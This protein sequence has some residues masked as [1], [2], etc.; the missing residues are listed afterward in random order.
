[1][2][3]ITNSYRYTG[4]YLDCGIS[5]VTADSAGDFVITIRQPAAEDEEYGQNAKVGISTLEARRL[6]S[7]LR[8]KGG[9]RFD[10]QVTPFAVKLKVPS[11]GW[12]SVKTKPNGD[13]EFAGQESL[14]GVFDVS[15]GKTEFVPTDAM[16]G[17][18]RITVP[19]DLLPDF[20]D[21]VVRLLDTKPHSSKNITDNLMPDMDFGDEVLGLLEKGRY[22]DAHEVFY[23]KSTAHHKAKTAEFEARY[24]ATSPEE[25]AA[26]DDRRREAA[27]FILAAL[28]ET[29]HV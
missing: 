22:L 19:A 25:K 15:D 6:L 5:C 12:V 14:G 18:A 4:F 8:S 1:M 9:T 7:T 11:N 29:G 23:I 24:N 16:Y 20:I 28:K 13:V 2:I 27:R 17:A 3:E 21:A 10:E 26:A